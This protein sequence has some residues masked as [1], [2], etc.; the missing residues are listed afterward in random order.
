MTYNSLLDEKL[1]FGAFYTAI[2][3]PNDLNWNIATKVKA[4]L[5]IY[6]SIHCLYSLAFRLPPMADTFQGKT[7]VYVFNNENSYVSII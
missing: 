2:F 5:A 6:F 7:G 4:V 1:S 3:S